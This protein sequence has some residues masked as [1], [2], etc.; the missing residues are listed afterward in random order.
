MSEIPQLLVIE[1][2]KDVRE[3]IIDSLSLL[4]IEITSAENGEE[5]LAAIQA[6]KFHAV[7]S[8]INMPKMNGLEVLK[9]TRESGLEV[10]F[11]VLSG[12]GDKANT[13]E[14]LRL[15]AFDFLDKPFDISH[16]EGVVLKALELG[17]LI[18]QI[19]AEFAAAQTGSNVTADAIKLITIKKKLLL[20]KYMNSQPGK[21]NK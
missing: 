11:I 4:E 19:D 14:A 20:M 12:F 13:V 17:K 2:D 9:K 8:D 18:S 16:L 10:P 6:K 21:G 3:A 7:L 15:G 5:G 1:D